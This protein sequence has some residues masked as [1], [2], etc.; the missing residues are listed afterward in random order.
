[1]RTQEGELCLRVVESAD[2]RPGPRVVASFAAK[3]SAVRPA[4]RHTIFELA[5]VNIFMTTCTGHVFKV[6]RNDFVRSARSADFMAFGASYRDVRTGQGKLCLPMLGDS[7]Q[8]A[9]PIRYR[10]AA[11]AAIAKRL[12]RKLAVVGVLVAVGARSKLHFVNRVLACGQ[13]TFVAIHFCVLPFQRI[14]GSR[15]FLDAKERRLPPYHFVT[16]G[17]LAFLRAVLELAVM[18][19]LMAIRAVGKLERTLEVPACMAS[20]AT[21]FDVGAEE[22]VFCLGMVEGKLR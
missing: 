11:L 3:R 16:F 9:V 12:L 8:S 2:V 14:L 6:E 7:K 20:N 10:V 21:H 17:A 4:L 5:M 19:I 1:M 22:G 13:M 18:N 15:M